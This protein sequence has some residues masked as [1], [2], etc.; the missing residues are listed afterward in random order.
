MNQRQACS[1][2]DVTPETLSSYHAAA[3]VATVAVYSI[4]FSYSN[5]QHKPSI[6]LRLQ[7]QGR[8]WQAALGRLE[9]HSCHSI[10]AD[11]ATLGTRGGLAAAFK[12]SGVF[13]KLV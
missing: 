9:G 8:Q 5:S 1:R 12:S 2:G 10:T 4:G 6:P 11:V 3:A 13:S 7:R